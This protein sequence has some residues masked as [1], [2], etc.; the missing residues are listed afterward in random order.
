MTPPRAYVY[1]CPMGNARDMLQGG[2][3]CHCGAEVGPG[4]CGLLGGRGHD[5]GGLPALAQGAVSG[6]RVA[7]GSP[8]IEVAGP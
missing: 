5:G 6:W 8:V 2:S 1:T 3:F 7:L 4:P